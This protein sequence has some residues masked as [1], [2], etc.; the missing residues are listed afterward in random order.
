MSLKD[1]SELA[2][3]LSKLKMIFIEKKGPVQDRNTLQTLIK[4]LATSLNPSLPIALHEA[5]L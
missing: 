2:A 1:W 5:T 4:R 3:W